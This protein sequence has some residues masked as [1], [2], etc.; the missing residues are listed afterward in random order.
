MLNFK[1]LLKRSIQCLFSENELKS[2]PLAFPKKPNQVWFFHSRNNRNFCTVTWQRT[3]NRNA[4][5]SCLL[6]KALESLSSYIP[7]SQG[8]QCRKES[9]RGS[10]AFLSWE[11]TKF[12]HGLEKLGSLASSVATCVVR[13]ATWRET[14]S[15][16]TSYQLPT[17]SSNTHLFDSSAPSLQRGTQ[18]P[19]TLPHSKEGGAFLPLRIFTLWSFCPRNQRVLLYFPHFLTAYDSVKSS[20]DNPSLLPNMFSPSV[21]TSA[22][23]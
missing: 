14:V 11:I 16:L 18:Q 22:T 5:P 8:G 4:K 23:A 1:C 7:T 13:E 12:G 19:S 2:K 17:T 21:P 15:S 9:V 20:L 10:L 6:W 3:K